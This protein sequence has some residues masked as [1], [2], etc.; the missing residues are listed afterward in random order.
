MTILALSQLREKLCGKRQNMFQ[1]LK[2]NFYEAQTFE[3]VCTS[4]Q[5]WKEEDCLGPVNTGIT[6]H[7]V[8]ILF[9]DF[10]MEDSSLLC[11]KCWGMA[12]QSENGK[13]A[14][15]NCV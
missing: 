10:Q 5:Q 1:L 13:N 11:C 15:K 2:N 9:R 7:Y 3:D 14:E 12:K 8:N 4:F 6:F